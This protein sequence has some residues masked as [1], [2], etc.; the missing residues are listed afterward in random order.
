M[1]AERREEVHGQ[2]G[3]PLTGIAISCHVDGA[4]G[5]QGSRVA[6]PGAHG[7]LA[8]DRDSPPGY[9]GS[10]KHHQREQ[11]RGLRRHHKILIAIAALL[12]V[13][14]LAWNAL[15]VESDVP[16][17]NGEPATAQAR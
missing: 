5:S 7:S 13:S 4:R 17:V 3:R 1:Y 8:I 12:A 6:P 16:R 9:G 2:A 11:P 15:L 10:V 14:W